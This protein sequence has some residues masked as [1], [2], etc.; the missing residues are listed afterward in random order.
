MV[1]VKKSRNGNNAQLLVVDTA[2]RRHAAEPQAEEAIRPPLGLQNLKT[3]KRVIMD[4]VDDHLDQ[5]NL[6]A[7]GLDVGL[8]R[9]N[10]HSHGD[11]ALDIL[12]NVSTQTK[13]KS[14]SQLA[15]A[16][17]LDSTLT[18]VREHVRNHLIES[19]DVFRLLDQLGGTILNKVVES[20]QHI[21]KVELGARF[22]SRMNQLE[23]LPHVRRDGL[24]SEGAA[25]DDFECFVIKVYRKLAWFRKSLAVAFTVELVLKCDLD[26]RHEDSFNVKK[27]IGGALKSEDQGSDGLQDTKSSNALVVVRN[28]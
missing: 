24:G 26:D 19:L 22:E 7:L 23:S 18:N 20:R 21:L 8:S 5:I 28:V 27:H 15:G 17:S 4:G 14:L 10:I 6:V 16:Y 3:Q 11:E 1:E 13:H 12:V 2:K 9:Q 25:V